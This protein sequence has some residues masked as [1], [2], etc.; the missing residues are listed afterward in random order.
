[1]PQHL[2]KPVVR[3][4]PRTLTRRPNNKKPS[5]YS[6]MTSNSVDD[7]HFND[8]VLKKK[9]GVSDSKLFLPFLE[10]ARKLAE[11]RVC[12]NVIYPGDEACYHCKKKLPSWRC[13]ICD[14]ASHDKCAAFPEYVVRS[15]HA[16]PASSIEEVFRRLPLPYMEKEFSIDLT[17]VDNLEPP[18][19]FQYA[20]PA[21]SIKEVD[22]KDG[23]TV[24]GFDICPQECICRCLYISCSSVCKCSENCTNRPFQ[25]AKKIKLIMTQ[26]RGWGV[27]AAE[28]INEGDFIIEYVGEVIDDAICEKRFWDMKTQGITQFYMVSV[29]KD[30][31][32]DASVKGNESRFLNHSCDPNCDL[33]QWDVNGMTC[34]GIFANNSIEPGEELT[35]DYR[36]ELYGEEVKCRC[37]ASNCRGHL[38][39]KKK[40]PELKK[41]KK[42][43]KRR[44]APAS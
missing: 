19:N 42:G 27:E 15:N 16:A 12:E 24:C 43:V 3:S 23:C 13:G 37:G 8:S 17:M 31:N 21:R 33:Q 4:S 35:F 14:L 32:I 22:E 20:V 18:L 36:F 28:F 44:R 41:T 25:E 2:S 9:S 38:G 26:D 5:T 11:C 7:D 1:M 10:G 40:T 29:R 39:T 6:R 30:F 34:L